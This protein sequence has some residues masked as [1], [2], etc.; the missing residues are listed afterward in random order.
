MTFSDIEYNAPCDASSDFIA[1]PITASVCGVLTVSL[2]MIGF[3]PWTSF[4]LLSDCVPSSKRIKLFT[5]N[6]TLSV[7]VSNMIPSVSSD[8]DAK[9]PVPDSSLNITLPLSLSRSS[10]IPLTIALWNLS[11]VSL[12]C[13]STLSP[14]SNEPMKG[15]MIT[16]R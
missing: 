15:S 6:A 8:S 4:K 7:A 3:L 1:P 16:N 12:D 5:S 13:N 9:N 11:G 2:T 14:I 10:T